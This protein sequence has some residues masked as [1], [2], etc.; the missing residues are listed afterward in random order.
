MKQEYKKEVIVMRV[1][2]V[3]MTNNMLNSI[4]KNKK[5]LSTKYDQY[6]TGQ[7]IQKPSE[8]PVVAVRS[9]KY[10]SNLKELLQY[11]E[12]N[13]P[14]AIAW[15]EITEGAL[16]NMNDLLTEMNYYCVQG[17]T[18]TYETIDRDS[19]AQ[20]LEQYRE[21]IYR[22]L[23][24]DYGGR[25]VFSGYRTNTPVLFPEESRDI[26]YSIQESIAFANVDKM[27]YVVGE[28]SFTEGAT[29]DD[30]A[31]MAP[32]LKEAYR[33]QVAYDDVDELTG[34]TYID[35]DGNEVDAMTAFAVKQ[36]LS[37]DT[38]PDDRNYS[39]YTAEEDG[40]TFIKDTGELILSQKAYETLR[41]A[42]A[43]NVEYSKTNFD[44]LDV[45]PEFYFDCTTY[46]LDADG[47]V[48]A[49]EEPI[50][51]TKPIEQ[52]IYYEVNF[53]Q[54]LKVN[55]MANETIDTALAR[56][57]DNIM[58]KVD[59]AYNVQT[60]L[61]EVERMLKDTSKTKQEK[62]ALNQLKEQLTTEFTLKKSILQETFGKAITTTKNVQSG[63]KSARP[64]GSVVQIGVSVASTSLGSRYTRLELIKDRLSD[65]KTSFTEIL[66]NNE[67][68][69]LEDAIINYND[70]LLTYNSSLS[71]AGKAVQN[72]L[73][74]FLR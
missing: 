18:D 58:S 15:M 27:S 26:K 57:I 6:A 62:E 44:T 38:D 51:Y 72:S 4:T 12:K 11:Y 23:D 21:Q 14:D 5:D 49:D 1:T 61:E 50:N 65:Q 71:A 59:D 30:Y 47:N 55:T 56:Q 32:T 54:K 22:C 16:D 63:K 2:N 3:M 34:F 45:K 46:Q 8:D 10:R 35:S 48:K 69:N 9:L 53:K 52:D 42:K 13:I 73:L 29:V 68:V 37:T 66:D 17:S 39:P 36:V 20:T 25:Y 60:K 74:D 40:V 64:D 33:L 41:T 7:K 67:R 31:K 19:I 28:V 24:T 43:I 70:A